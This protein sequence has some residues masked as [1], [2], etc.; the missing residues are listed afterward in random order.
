MDLPGRVIKASPE[1][2]ADGDIQ[3]HEMAGD[4]EKLEVTGDG[5]GLD[6]LQ[7]DGV[8]GDQKDATGDSVEDDTSAATPLPL[9]QERIF[10][11][12]NCWCMF[13]VGWDCGTLGPLLP[14]IQKHY[15]VRLPSFKVS[16]DLWPD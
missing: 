4:L 10:L 11:A 1:K 3:H 7:I 8:S 9:K 6:E 15:H 5:P 12:A 14:T 16:I 13:L 2:R